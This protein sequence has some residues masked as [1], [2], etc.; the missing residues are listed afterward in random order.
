MVCEGPLTNH[1]VL[2][3]AL[4]NLEQ[5]KGRA[6]GTTFQEI[7]KK[8]FR[9]MLAL[10]PAGNALVA[11]EEQVSP[12]YDKITVNLQ[13]SRTLASIRDALLARLISGELWVPDAERMTE[14]ALSDPAAL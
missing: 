9:P 4:N 12:L 3:W 2:H 5:I 8:N 14:E 1:Y 11:F 10:V 7:S 6:S 13:Q